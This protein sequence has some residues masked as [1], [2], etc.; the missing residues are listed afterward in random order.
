NKGIEFLQGVNGS[1]N[2]QIF[3]LRITNGKYGIVANPVS[4][5]GVMISHSVIQT[6]GSDSIGV[7]ATDKFNNPQSLSFSDTSFSSDG[8][9]PVVMHGNGVMKFAHSTFEEWDEYAIVL[10]NGSLIAYD[11][12]FLADKQSI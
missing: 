3:G 1:T 9:T 11:N 2:G 5:I 6:I 4:E 10:H 8:G 7:L 12:K